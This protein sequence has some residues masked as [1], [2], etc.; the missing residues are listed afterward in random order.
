MAACLILCVCVS[1]HEC[2]R[3]QKWRCYPVVIHHTRDTRSPALLY[4]EA[5]FYKRI[6][7]QRAPGG[8]PLPP[9]ATCKDVH[10]TSTAFITHLYLFAASRTGQGFFARWDFDPS[11]VCKV[12]DFLLSCSGDMED[13]TTGT[14]HTNTRGTHYAHIW[15]LLQVLNCIKMGKSSSL[16]FCIFPAQQHNLFNNCFNC[17]LCC[18]NDHEVTFYF[19]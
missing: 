4:T 6:T 18:F 10:R 3:G 12:L 5:M 15:A 16:L 11:N 19:P 7:R 2:V 8:H 17:L 1:I 14:V 13:E 9:R